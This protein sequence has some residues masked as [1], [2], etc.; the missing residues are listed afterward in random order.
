[1]NG[2]HAVLR[3]VNVRQACLVVVNL[4]FVVQEV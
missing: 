4:G 3:P 2:G 1:M